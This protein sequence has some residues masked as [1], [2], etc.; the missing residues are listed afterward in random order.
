MQKDITD[1][2]WSD[3][4]QRRGRLLQKRR[5]RVKTELERRGDRFTFTERRNE[6]ALE[7]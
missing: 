7:N 2:L 4:E 3:V 1:I 6:R 5:D